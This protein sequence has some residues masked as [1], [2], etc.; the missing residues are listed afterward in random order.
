MNA[1]CTGVLVNHHPNFQSSIPNRP[2]LKTMT[3]APEPKKTIKRDTLAAIEEEM[4]AYWEKEKVFEVDAPSD[5]NAEK[6]MVSFPYPYMNGRLHLG[7]SFSLSKCEFAAGYQRMLGKHVLFPFGFHCTGMPIKACA[8]KLKREMEMYGNPPQF[9]VEEEVVE[10]QDESGEAE[11]KVSDGNAAQGFKKKGKV[12]SKATGKKYQWEIMKSIGVDEKEI[13]K[14]SDAN[15]WLHYFPPIA[16][17]YT[18][19]LSK[20]SLFSRVG[21]FETIW[22]SS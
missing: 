4:Q 9:P 2:N 1:D 20:I 19:F 13:P 14:F 21:R 10:G 18:Y 15:Y 22:C 8:D 12:A 3:A 5:P 6:Y 17:V 11:S 16:M 7:H